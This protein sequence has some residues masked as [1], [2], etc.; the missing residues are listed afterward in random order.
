MLFRQLFDSGTGTYTY[1]VADP[2]TLEAALIDP[3]LEQVERDITLLTQ[4]GLTLYYCIETHIHADH[5]TGASELRRLTGCTSVVPKLTKVD[6]ANQT[7]D[8]GDRLSLGTIPIEAI[9][10]PGH[11]DSH[12]AYLVNRTHL[13]TGDALLIRGCGRTD[14]QGGDAGVLY[15]RVTQRLFSLPETTLVYPGHDYHGHT[16][17]TIGEEKRWNPR[18]FGRGRQGFID[19]METLNLPNPKKMA[20]AV[21]ANKQCGKVPATADI[22]F[23][24]I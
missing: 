18:F 13:L 6:C 2:Q 7:L 10:T 22:T 17:S 3:V 4:L 24:V 15:D 12:L 11:T 23:A 9:A 20:E 16:V 14:F 19:Y 5:I 21:P 1:L 8:D